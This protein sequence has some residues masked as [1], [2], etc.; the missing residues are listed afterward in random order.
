METIDGWD[1]IFPMLGEGLLTP[2]LKVGVSGFEWSAAE[3][4]SRNKPRMYRDFRYAQ[5]PIHHNS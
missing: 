4:K 3:W 2:P 5:I 1:F